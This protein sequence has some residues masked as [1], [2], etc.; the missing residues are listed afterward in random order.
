MC[1]C[2]KTKHMIERGCDKITMKFMPKYGHHISFLIVM[3]SHLALILL[4][5]IIP[6]MKWWW[7]YPLNFINRQYRMVVS[8]SLDAFEKPF[9]R[10]FNKNAQ[11][12]QDRAHE[13][14]WAFTRK[15]LGHSVKWSLMI[16]YKAKEPRFSPSG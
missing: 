3:I 12:C 14:M 9:K 5:S 4:K 6:S 11:D 15:H 2:T 10:V 13:R 16:H 8:I 7:R 1:W